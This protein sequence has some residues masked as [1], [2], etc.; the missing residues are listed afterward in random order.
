MT[1]ERATL[2]FLGYR[3]D[4]MQFALKKDAVSSAKTIDLEPIF[5]RTIRQGS[6][7]EHYVSIGVE[8]C[9]PDLPFDAK[10][11]LTGR[12]KYDGEMDVQ[13]LL[14]VNAAAILYPYV[15]STLSMMTTLAGMPPVV[16][17]TINF[18]KLFEQEDRKQEDLPESK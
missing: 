6:D 13:N 4:A 5:K 3:V 11:I 18:A 9:Q 14:K 8:L 1:P 7:S 12:F 16:V 2:Q 10:I 17:P 15:R